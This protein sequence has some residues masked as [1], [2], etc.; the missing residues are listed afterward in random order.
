MKNQWIYFLFLVMCTFGL[1]AQTEFKVSVSQKE[2]P[3]NNRFSITFTLDK[4]HGSDDGEIQYPNFYDFDLVGNSSS[5][6]MNMR[7]SS[8]SKTLTFQAQK[9]GSYTI[10]KASVEVDGKVYQTKPFVI[11]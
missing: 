10:G 5:T 11:K 7:K 9:E 2:V 3:L 6:Q 8:Y 1:K 4:N